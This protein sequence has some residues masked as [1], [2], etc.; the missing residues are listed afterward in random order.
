MWLVEEPGF[1]LAHDLKLVAL[2]GDYGIRVAVEA[3][4]GRYAVDDADR[5]T[6]QCLGLIQ[7]A[8]DENAHVAL[9]PEMAVPELAIA[10]LI[11]AIRSTPQPLVLIGGIE[12]LPPSDYRALVSK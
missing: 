6:A 8:S 2:Q 7:R 4:G 10:P 12:G 1:P 11:E 9:I 5:A 3:A